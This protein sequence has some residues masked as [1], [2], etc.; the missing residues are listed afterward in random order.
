VAAAVVCSDE[1]RHCSLA[2]IDLATGR[3]LRETANN[4]LDGKADPFIEVAVAGNYIVVTTVESGSTRLF[5]FSATDLDE[6]LWQR[7]NPSAQGSVALIADQWACAVGC[8][9]LADASLAP[10]GSDALPPHRT[11]GTPWVQYIDIPDNAGRSRVYRYDYDGDMVTWQQWSPADDQPFP[12]SAP[13][14]FDRLSMLSLPLVNNS[15]YGG[16]TMLLC[17]GDQCTPWSLDGSRRYP[18]F[19]ASEI[20][21]LVESG[22]TLFVLGHTNG[23]SLKVTLATGA[24]EKLPEYDWCVVPNDIA[25]CYIRSPLLIEAVDP[26]GTADALWSYIEEA[27]GAM[28]GVTDSTMYLVDW[29]NHTVRFA[30]RR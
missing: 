8:W 22:E 16:S 12:G 13:I 28:F 18:P 7:P 11:S 9:S 27:E 2:T 6:P 3:V 29:A 14:T 5:G 26:A 21:T 10:F 23:P 24:T 4:H 15:Y 17:S 25:Y 20:N 19:G 30:S 1:T